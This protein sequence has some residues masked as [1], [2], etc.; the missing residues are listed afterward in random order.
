MKFPNTVKDLE[1]S[2]LDSKLRRIQPGDEVS[3]MRARKQAKAQAPAMFAYSSKY[4]ML[5][6]GTDGIRILTKIRVDVLQTGSEI[7]PILKHPSNLVS[8][9]VPLTRL[10]E[11]SL[12]HRGRQVSIGW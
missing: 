11:L 12:R 7:L 3:V 6:A 4:A 8:L 5:A 9:D 10:P 2:M 1:R